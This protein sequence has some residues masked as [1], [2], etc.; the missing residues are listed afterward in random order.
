MMLAVSCLL[1]FFNARQGWIKYFLL[2][3]PLL[4][5]FFKPNLKTVFSINGLE[6]YSLNQ[7]RAYYQ[8]P[9]LGRFFENKLNRYIFSY[10]KNLFEGL[11]INYYFFASHPRERVG[12]Y[13]I[14]KFPE[15]ALL[16]FLIGL[17]SS[18]RR[19]QFLGVIYFL[20]SLLVASF[21]SPIDTLSFLFFPFFVV[22]IYFGAKECFGFFVFAS[23]RLVTTLSNG[24]TR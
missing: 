21:F 20:F 19:K 9:L 7:R 13:E 15:L 16:F 17:Y 11:D 12:A 22:N 10:E 3:L 14:K 1:V 4:L 23:S 8:S 24:K 5:I 6:I 18:L 2:L